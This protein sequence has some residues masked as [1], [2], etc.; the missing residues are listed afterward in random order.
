MSEA[1][2]IVQRHVLGA[3]ADALPASVLSG[4]IALLERDWLAPALMDDALDNWEEAGG[5]EP[6]FTTSEGLNEE[7]VF[8]PF[9]AYTLDP[10]ASELEVLAIGAAGGEPRFFVVS[11]S[12]GN[13]TGAAFSSAGDLVALLLDGSFESPV[14]A[15]RASAELL[16]MLQRLWGE[17]SFE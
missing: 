12:G 8:H 16:E 3:S 4:L 15:A 10:E 7:T 9:V 11:A 14:G 1:S 6:P 2:L 13:P 5:A 17:R